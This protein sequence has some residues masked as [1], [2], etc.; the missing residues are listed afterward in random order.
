MITRILSTGICCAL[1]ITVLIKR[2]KF[3]NTFA[4]CVPHAEH[5][6]GNGYHSIKKLFILQQMEQRL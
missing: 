2:Q 3:R 6:W 4:A 1:N 5:P